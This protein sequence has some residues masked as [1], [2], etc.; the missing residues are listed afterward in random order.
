MIRSKAD[1][2]R[3]IPPPSMARS[4]QRIACLGWIISRHCDGV[5]LNHCRTTERELTDLIYANRKR[6][7]DD[8]RLALGPN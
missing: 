6:I 2:A 7:N 3:F 1:A 8:T 5:W 4:T